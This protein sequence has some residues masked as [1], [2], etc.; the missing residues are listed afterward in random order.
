MV[1]IVVD[2]KARIAIA[3]RDGRIVLKDGTTWTVSEVRE[4]LA[5]PKPGPAPAESQ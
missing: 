3:L 4:E 1:G 5:A 2:K